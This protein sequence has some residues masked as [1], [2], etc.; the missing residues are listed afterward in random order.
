MS[1]TCNSLLHEQARWLQQYPDGV[2]V[3]A[4]GSISELLQQDSE[5]IDASKDIDAEA[6]CVITHVQYVSRG[7]GI[8]H[9]GEKIH[10][11]TVAQ[12]V[13]QALLHCDTTSYQTEQLELL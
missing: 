13:R 1:N 2:F 6:V 11:A 4:Y 7:A 5:D 10:G 3:L 9:Q 8:Y 12:K